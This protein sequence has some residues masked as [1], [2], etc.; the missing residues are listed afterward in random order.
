MK[1]KLLL[2]AMLFI[3]GGLSTVSA[4]HK[5]VAGKA[6]SFELSFAPG[7]SKEPITGRMF[8][9]VSYSDTIE[10]RLQVGRYG[11]QFFGVDV[12]KLQPSQP[13]T[14]DASTLGY[15]VNKMKDIPPGDYY[16]QA[17]LSKYT[18][19]KRSDGHTLWMHMDQWE[20]QKWE[21]SPGNIYGKVVK[22]SI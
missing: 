10:P 1:N 11:T 12:T 5:A 4:Q 17:V 16:V 9:V 3:A 2:I 7:I 19:F 8:L 15:P 18:E 13:V 22:I 6:T 20:G 14:I 21:T